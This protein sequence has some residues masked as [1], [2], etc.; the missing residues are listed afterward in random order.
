MFQTSSV[1]RTTLLFLQQL[2]DEG[3]ILLD[4]RTHC[5]HAGYHIEG[6]INIP[7]DEIEV[8]KA[9]IC[10]WKKPVITF[11]TYG[12]RSRIAAAKLKSMGLEVFDAGSM[13]VVEKAKRAMAQ[14]PGFSQ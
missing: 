11:S 2:L 7:Y 8:L 13:F 9:V 3:A 14:Q 6:A 1:D 10:D 5:E 4:V 12:R